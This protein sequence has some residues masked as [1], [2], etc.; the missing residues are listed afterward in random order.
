MFVDVSQGDYHL[1]ASSPGKGAGQNGEDLGA[2]P[3]GQDC[4]IIGRMR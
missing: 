1:E 2:Y 4:T 3:R